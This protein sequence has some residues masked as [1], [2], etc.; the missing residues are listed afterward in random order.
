MAIA[1]VASGVLHSV[2]GVQRTHRPER[3]PAARSNTVQ[4]PV[5]LGLRKSRKPT[6]GSNAAG[7]D[8]EIVI[9]QGKM[10]CDLFRRESC[11]KRQTK[12]RLAALRF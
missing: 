12:S 3:Q 9:W 7:V 1:C 4:Q 6:M 2:G 11:W 10:P 8:D 5:I